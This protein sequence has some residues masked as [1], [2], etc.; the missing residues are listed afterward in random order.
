MFGLDIN[1][2]SKDDAMP[3]LKARILVL[4]VSGEASQQYIPIMNCIFAAQKAVSCRQFNA[5]VA[6]LVAERCVEQSIPIDVCKIYGEDA[7]F[8]QQAAHL[9]KASY[10]RLERR[11]GL[12]QY[13]MMAFLPGIAVRKHLHLPTQ[14]QIDLRA[15]CF[16]HKKIV[17]IGYVC[18]VCLSSRCN[19]RARA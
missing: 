6:P 4:S 12:L 7:V 8:L 9:T 10:Y 18:S 2:I 1:R 3:P 5:Y 13:L 17:D 14:E 19:F 16:C 15:A 11:S